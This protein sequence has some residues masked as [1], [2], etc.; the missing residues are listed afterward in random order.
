VN[1]HY[2]KVGFNCLMMLI[3]WNCHLMFLSSRCSLIMFNFNN[4]RV[5][6]PH[7]KIFLKIFFK[8][9]A[10]EILKLLLI[11]IMLFC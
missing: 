3:Q 2:S 10:K 8:S 5:I 1:L 4:L 7:C 9:A 11:R 6:L